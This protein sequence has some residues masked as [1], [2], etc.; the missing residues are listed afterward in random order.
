LARAAMFLG[1]ICNAPPCSLKSPRNNGARAC[2]DL[3]I[4]GGPHGRFPCALW[5]GTALCVRTTE[6]KIKQQ[7]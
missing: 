3:R 6:V 2:V 4:E 7:E 5:D 1:F